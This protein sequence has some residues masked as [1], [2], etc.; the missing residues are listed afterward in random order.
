MSDDQIVAI[1]T[2]IIGQT[3]FETRREVGA[4]QKLIEV[5]VKTARAILDA[6]KPS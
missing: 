6:S 1:I 4:I 3:D 5:K 2:A